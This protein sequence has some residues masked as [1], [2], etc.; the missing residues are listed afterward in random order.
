MPFLKDTNGHYIPTPS[1]Q[2]ADGREVSLRVTGSYLQW[3]YEDTEWANLIDLSEFM[4]TGPSGAAATIEVGTVTTGEPGTSVI[5]TNTG[6]SAQAVLNFTIPSGYDGDAIST[7]T[8]VYS[9]STSDWTGPSSGV[10]SYSVS[11]S[12]HELGTDFSADVYYLSS[13]VY[14]KSHGHYTPPNW[15]IEI[16]STGDVVLK[17]TAVFA[18]KLVLAG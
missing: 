13:G 1:S 9:F 17:T 16:G 14:I 3:R 7:I 12:A 4:I 11:A 10:Y 8:K 6:T 15:L 18:G 5:V 2:G